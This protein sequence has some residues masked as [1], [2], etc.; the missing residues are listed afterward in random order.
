MGKLTAEQIYHKTHFMKPLSKKQLEVVERDPYWALVYCERV[1]NGRWVSAESYFLSE[2]S[3]RNDDSVYWVIDYCNKFIKGRW[4]ELEEKLIEF[5]LSNLCYLYAERVLEGRWVEGEDVIALSAE[6]SVDY[7][8]FLGCRFEM[9]E[10]VIMR[11]PVFAVR[12]AERVLEGRWVS[13]ESFILGDVE[14]AIEYCSLIGDRWLELESRIIHNVNFCMRYVR[15]VRRRFPEFE[16][17]LVGLKSPNKIVQYFCIVGKVSEELHNKMVLLSFDER[18][19]GRVDDYFRIISERKKKYKRF[20]KRVRNCISVYSGKSV[21][22]VLSLLSS[23][24]YNH[25]DG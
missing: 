22:D 23:E 6:S 5:K 12:Y 1:L 4:K 11:D 16:K 15:N 8:E 9:G 18:H 10:G 25:I 3:L 7:A 21:D 2:S 19:K 13:A 14:N 24:E 20:L 17:R